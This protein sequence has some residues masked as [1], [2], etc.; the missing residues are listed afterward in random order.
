VRGYPD[1]DAT[2][3]LLGTL[4]SGG[5]LHVPDGRLLQAEPRQLLGWLREAGA[6]VVLGRTD[7][8]LIDRAGVEDA[9]LTVSAGWPEARLVLE[10]VRGGIVR[11]APGYR[12][13]VLDDRLRPVGPGKTGALYVAGA[14]VAYGYAG[15][16]AA[17]GERF[18]PDP[19]G[20][21]RG[22]TAVMWRSG[23]AALLANGSL[24]VLDDAPEH[25]PF[26]D[27]SATFVV[28]A[29]ALGRRALWPAA[30]A[31][32][33]GWRMTHA[34]DFYELCMEYLEDPF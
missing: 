2:L 27:E 11:P 16:S 20:G 17:T 30:A 19:F 29:D 8:E 24:R 15:L 18:L 4:V 23:R 26:T 10:R 7:P 13:Y 28:V 22:T 32:P 6:P 14:G 12:A 34:E 25:D 3:G 21:P 33:E 9:E 31:R 1:A 5:R